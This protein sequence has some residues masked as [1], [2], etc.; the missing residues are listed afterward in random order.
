MIAELLSTFNSTMKFMEQSVVDLS[1]RQM[2]EQPA[3]VPNHAA[4][5]LGHI[6]YGCQ[7]MA[8]ALG[9]E[10]WL[11]RE[12]PTLFGTDTIPLADVSRYPN[13]SALLALLKESASRLE[14]A[15]LATNESALAQPLPDEQCREILPTMGHALLQVMAAHTAFHAGQLSVWRRAIGL[16]PVSC[17]V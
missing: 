6:I 11:P 8:G 5:T 13:K 3:G 14:N 16:R 2:V 7:E 4:W 15:L 1:D 10:E 9:I 17:F 12:W